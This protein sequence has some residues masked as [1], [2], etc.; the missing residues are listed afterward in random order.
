MD[1][2]VLDGEKCLRWVAMSVGAE[3]VSSVGTEDMS[4]VA[5][6][7]MFSIPTACCTADAQTLLPGFD[8]LMGI[9]FYTLCDPSIPCA[10][11]L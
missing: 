2:N 4:F 9:V 8:C 11:A 3:D 7:D 6:E 10:S 5:T 1:S